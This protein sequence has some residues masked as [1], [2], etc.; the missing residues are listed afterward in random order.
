MGQASSSELTHV[1]RTQRDTLILGPEPSLP[2]TPASSFLGLGFP[3]SKGGHR[4][5]KEP[6]TGGIPDP[7]LVRLA[8]TPES[9]DLQTQPSSGP[10]RSPWEQGSAYLEG[11]AQMPCRM[12]WCLSP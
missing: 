3:I 6:F 11:T 10:A 1:P 7:E 12:R 2:P 8:L 4:E 5:C 9:G